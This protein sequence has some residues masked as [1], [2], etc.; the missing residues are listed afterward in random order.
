MSDPRSNSEIM[1]VLSSIRRLVSEGRKPASVAEAP[2]EADAATP[3]PSGARFVLTPS[4][5]VDSA[6]EPSASGPD[7]DATDA[8]DDGLVYDWVRDAQ[9]D[10]QGSAP[11]RQ[12]GSLE[13]TIA[14]LE[15]AVSEIETEFEPDVGDMEENLLAP[16]PDIDEPAA[17]A[18]RPAVTAFHGIMAGFDAMPPPEDERLDAAITASGAEGDAVAPPLAGPWRTAQV[19]LDSALGDQAPP[20]LFLRAGRPAAAPEPG[21]EQAAEDSL[22]A[23]ERTEPDDTAEDATLDDD[24]MVP[25]T[26]DIDA[27]G[28][29]SAPGGAGQDSLISGSNGPDGEKGAGL[30]ADAPDAGRLHFG[31]TGRRLRIERSQSDML[32]SDEDAASTGSA[33]TGIGDVVDAE[34]GDGVDLFDPLADADVDIDRMRDMVAE[35]VREELRGQLGE[36]I[37][38]NLRRLVQREIARALSAETGA[39]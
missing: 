33:E 16:L 21:P 36:K 25:A 12:A 15:A 26:A 8:R 14:E 18:P 37:T 10:R 3:A 4:L 27:R 34:P 39:E 29:D 1:D 5:R 17:P 22:L 30:D 23:G 19:S 31:G 7:A 32:L 28:P 9:S 13:E 35:L 6:N 38:R 20:S 11:G 24:R 2:P